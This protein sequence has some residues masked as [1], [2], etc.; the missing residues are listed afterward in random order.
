M[1]KVLDTGIHTAEENMEI[2]RKLLVD[3]KDEPILHLYGWAKP[4][5]TFGHFIKI[6]EHLKTPSILDLAKRPTGGGIIFHTFDLAFSVLLPASHPEFSDNTLSNYHY[7]N[8]AVARALK[9]S[10]LLP[11]EPVPLDPPSKHFCMAKPTKYDVMIG[12]RKLAGAAQRK[13][14]QGLLHQG[15]ISIA[16]PNEAFLDE[17]LLPDSRVK[18]AMLENSY[19]LLTHDYT[20]SDLQAMRREIEEKLTRELCQKS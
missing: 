15:S 20:P 3:L 5:A 6:G 1:W 4:S 18:E 9:A 10:D 19:A 11:D 17:V 13:M 14:K 7:I 2:D 8:S 12:G 16:P